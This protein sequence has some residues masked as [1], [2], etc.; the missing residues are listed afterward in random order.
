VLLEP[1][2]GTQGGEMNRKTRIASTLAVTGLLSLV[3]P[4]AADAGTP[5]LSG[6]G[7]PGT[8]EQ[9]IVGSTLLGGAQGGSG[10]GGSSGSGTGGFGGLGG[11]SPSGSGNSSGSGAVGGTSASPADSGGRR[12]GSTNAAGEAAGRSSGARAGRLRAYVY[13]SKTGA[14]SAIGLSGDD[15]L[16]LIA[17]VATL[18]LVGALT[19]RLS[20][21][22]A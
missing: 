11:G 3:A 21:L 8:G 22:Q 6:Y 15:V 5:L 19:L 7:G 18:V 1:S 4:V 17:I 2:K 9:A 14:S 20:R 12:A 10:G 16:A 13:P